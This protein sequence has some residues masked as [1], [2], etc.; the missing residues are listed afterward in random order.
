[1]VYWFGTGVLEPIG[2]HSS[3]YLGAMGN[4]MLA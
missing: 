4:V 1:M 3:L 2:Q